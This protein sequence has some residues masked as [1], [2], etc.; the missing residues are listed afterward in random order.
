MFEHFNRTTGIIIALAMAVIV[1]TAGVI[2]GQEQTLIILNP[3]QDLTAI[4]SR[5]PK[6]TVNLMLDYQDGRVQVFPEAPLTYGQSVFNLL[7]Q[8]AQNP[9]NQLDFSYNLNSAT[10]QLENFSISGL[11]NS[12]GGRK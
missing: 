12:A 6:I 2:I 7:N 5:S 11:T 4:F 3:D 8:L 1:W 10:G 9:A